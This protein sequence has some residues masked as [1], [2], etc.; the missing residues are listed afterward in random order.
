LGKDR[1]RRQDAGAFFLRC[2]P[3]RHDEEIAVEIPRAGVLF[4]RRRG[5]KLRPLQS[6][7]I[8]TLLPKLA[9]DLSQP[10]DNLAEIF[11]GAHE[12]HR[13]E[14]GFGGGEHLIAEASGAPDVGFL[15][16]EPFVNGLAKCLVQIDELSVRNIRLYTGS[17]QSLVEA[18]PANSLARVDILYPD[19]WPKRR[20]LKRRLISDATLRALAR[21]MRADAEL[22]FATDIDDYAAWTLARLLRSADFLW[23]A[24]SNSDWLAPWPGWSGTRYEEKA[25]REGRAPAYLT[26]RRK[27]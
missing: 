16:C 22:R 15:G 13:L 19:P 6:R 17:A 5:K 12:E 14:I 20:H 1:P 11:G 2:D 7:L 25:L 27:G 4:G 8:D 9:V 24:K 3:S 23:E 26:F 10:I 21:V 18:L